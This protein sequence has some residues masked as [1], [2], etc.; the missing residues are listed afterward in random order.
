MQEGAC[1]QPAIQWRLP[2]STTE[3][4]SIIR[5]GPAGL[6]RQSSCMMQTSACGMRKQGSWQ[7]A[8]RIRASWTTSAVPCHVKM[9]IQT[10]CLSLPHRLLTALAQAHM[11]EQGA[12]GRRGHLYSSPFATLSLI[13]A[14]LKNHSF[15]KSL[16][17]VSASAI[18]APYTA[19]FRNS[20]PYAR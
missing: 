4:E 14:K 2:S 13:F 11:R 1:Q 18:P 7:D 6:I 20:S 3:V 12:D 9:L 17:C 19:K 8:P 16:P 5:L 10:Q 15:E